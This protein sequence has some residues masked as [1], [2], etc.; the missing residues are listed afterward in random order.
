LP[1]LILI[2]FQ[3]PAGPSLVHRVSEKNKQNWPLLVKVMNKY[4][5][6]CFWLICNTYLRC[7]VRSIN[8]S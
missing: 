4:Q 6:P 8:Q 1:L 7:A 3:E 5:L 2:E